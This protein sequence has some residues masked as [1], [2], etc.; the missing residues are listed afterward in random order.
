MLGKGTF[1]KEKQ[2]F[3]SEIYTSVEQDGYKYI[4]KDGE[5]NAVKRR[6]RPSELLKV[7]KVKERIGKV[8]E[9]A[10]KSHKHVTKVRNA[11]G[12]SYEAAS[13]AIEQSKEPRSVRTKKK[14][15]PVDV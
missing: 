10:E 6:Y 12:K 15:G 2:R 8:K 3:S 7:D 9:V 14:V 13:D 5:G 4:L 1:E 11:L